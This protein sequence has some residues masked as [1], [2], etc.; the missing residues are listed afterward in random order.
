[1]VGVDHDQHAEKPDA[2]GEHAVHPHPLLEHQ[3]SAEHDEDRAGEAK[4]RHVGQRDM[5]QRDEP[6]QQPRSMHHAAPELARQAIGAVGR[7]TRAHD[8][9]EHDQ[10]AAEIA[11]ELGFE[12]RDVLGQDAHGGV[13]KGKDQPGESHPHHAA[14]GGAQRRGEIEAAMKGGGGGADGHEGFVARFK[15]GNGGR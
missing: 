3:G 10:H 6:Q 2:G 7:E 14:Q 4:R 9:R 12:R 8:Q 1:M 15:G 11:Q 13:E 5:R